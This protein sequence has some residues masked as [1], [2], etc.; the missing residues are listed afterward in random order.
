V[1]PAGSKSHTRRPWNAPGYGEE[2]AFID[3]CSMTGALMEVVLPLAGPGLSTTAIL[4][5]LEAWNHFFRRLAVARRTGATVPL[6]LTTFLGDYS[7]DWGAIMAGASLLILPLLVFA[8]VI[9][10]YLVAGLTQGAVK[11]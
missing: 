3:G 4:I 7:I 6:A 8:L 10:R 1:L 11:G 2:L 9:R 5:F